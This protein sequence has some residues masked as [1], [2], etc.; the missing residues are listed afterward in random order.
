M[1]PLLRDTLCSSCRPVRVQSTHGE[2]DRLPR[3]HAEPSHSKL[4][5]QAGQPGATAAVR[6]AAK[7]RQRARIDAN[8]QRRP[9]CVV[10]VS[11][12][13]TSRRAKP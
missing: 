4:E 12:T 10:Q 13:E 5:H 8:A 3:H 2:G 7:T 1:L 9:G 11:D 6:C